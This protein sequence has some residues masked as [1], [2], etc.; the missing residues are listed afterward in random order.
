MLEKL[1]HEKLNL[2]LEST[3]I[4]NKYAIVQFVF[5]VI[6]IAILLFGIYRH[7]YNAGEFIMLFGLI[8]ETMSQ[9]T[10]LANSIAGGILKD[11][12]Y[13]CDYYDFINGTTDQEI[14]Y[15]LPVPV[16]M[17]CECHG[18]NPLLCFHSEH[19]QSSCHI[20]CPVIHSGKNM[21]M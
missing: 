3:K 1:W 19:L 6:G 9:I 20:R 16:K 5:R 13:L 10:G 4:F 15:M 21:C 18:S 12:K 11:T 17:G 14:G 7:R 2:S 8:E